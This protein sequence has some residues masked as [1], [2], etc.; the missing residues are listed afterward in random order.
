MAG[1]WGWKNCSSCRQCLGIS[2]RKKGNTESLYNPRNSTPPFLRHTES[3]AQ[4]H[5]NTQ[6]II[7]HNSQKQ[8]PPRCLMADERRTNV[9]HT[10]RGLPLAA[11]RVKPWRPAT[12]MELWRRDHWDGRWP[13]GCNSTHGEETSRGSE[14]QGPG[15]KRRGMAFPLDRRNVLE[16]EVA[17]QLWQYTHKWATVL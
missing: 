9:A 10:H 3:D 15:G 11:R 13:Q 2:P 16:L 5:T 7:T 8:K 6:S 1:W 17:A 14:C 12:Q 4:E